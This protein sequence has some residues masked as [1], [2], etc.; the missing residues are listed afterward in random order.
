M[1]ITKVFLLEQMARLELNY[2][3]DKFKADQNVFG[4][5]YEIFQ[6]CE[7]PGLKLAVDKCLKE[8]EFAPNIAGIMKYYKEL[9]TEKNDLVETIK[10]QYRTIRVI[11]GEKYDTATYKEIVDYILRFPK[12]TRKLEMVEFTQRA[13]SFS[14]DC[15]ACGR[16]DKP[17]I[18]EYIQGAR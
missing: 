17:T 8:N 2:G 14:H 6:D 16:V 15:D 1:G 9:E 18:K 4:L 13:V 7:E 3:K 10:H 12:K 5:W 11:W